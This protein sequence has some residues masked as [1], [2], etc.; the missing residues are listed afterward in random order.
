MLH[1]LAQNPLNP[2]MIP[3]WT[4]PRHGTAPQAWVRFPGGTAPIGHTG[5]GFAFDNEGPA[6]QA[7]LQPH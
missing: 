1:G 6:H 3:G 5:P 4:P 7:L 2:A